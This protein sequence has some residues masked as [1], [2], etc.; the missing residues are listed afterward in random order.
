MELQVQLSTDL[1]TS[2]WIA[3]AV[4]VEDHS[5]W[6]LCVRSVINA[7]PETAEDA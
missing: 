1:T 6:I 5:I 3:S 2:N 7:R 4:P